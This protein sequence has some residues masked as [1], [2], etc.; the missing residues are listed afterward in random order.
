[1]QHQAYWHR[2]GNTKQKQNKRNGTRKI[3]KL[4]VEKNIKP[5][6]RTAETTEKSQQM[7]TTISVL[8]IS[9]IP[10]SL[11]PET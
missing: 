1:M 2:R 8:L 10:V 7:Q 5:F 4:G 6:P 9:Y 11:Y 3:T